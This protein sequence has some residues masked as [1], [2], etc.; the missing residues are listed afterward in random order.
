MAAFY[1]DQA[2]Q[3]EDKKARGETDLKAVRLLDSVAQEEKF[4][5]FINNNF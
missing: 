3:Q 2:E 1:T 5:E 4:I